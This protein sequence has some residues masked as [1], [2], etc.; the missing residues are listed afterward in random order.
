MMYAQAG[1]P[2]GQAATTAKDMLTITMNRAEAV[3]IVSTVG[4]GFVQHTCIPP[5]FSIA[6]FLHQAHV[7]VVLLVTGHLELLPDLGS[8]VER[9]V[10]ND[11]GN[12]GERETV[13]QGELRGE[14]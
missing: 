2:V 7:N 8:V 6:V 10:N 9:N 13:G 4:L 11:S 1:N 14:E 5:I 3:S 12:G